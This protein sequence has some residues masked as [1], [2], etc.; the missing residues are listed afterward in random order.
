MKQE[1][2][3]SKIINKKYVENRLKNGEISIDK[4]HFAVL[5]D[6]D[7]VKAA[8]NGQ[9]K[10]EESRIQAEINQAWAE[11]DALMQTEEN[12]RI[13]DEIEATWGENEYEKMQ[14]IKLETDICWYIY[15]QFFPGKVNIASD[16][17]ITR[18][19]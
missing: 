1:K 7:C 11:Y 16:E 12:K 19:R 15:N 9:K 4:Y 14:Q 13:K 18:T 8:L 6:I 2:H 3:Y 5:N 17:E 10:L